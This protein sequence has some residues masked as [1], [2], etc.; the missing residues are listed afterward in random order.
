MATE[1]PI[2]N[3]ILDLAD[4][5]TWEHCLQ[6]GDESIP[7]WMRHCKAHDIRRIYLLGCGTSCY[8]GEVG[9]RIIERLVGLPAEAFYAFDLAHYGEPE[10]LGPEALVIGISTTG[11]SQE[12][13]NALI[14]AESCGASTLALTAAA[15]GDVAQAA[16]GAVLT[17]GEDDR[18]AVKS[19]SYVQTLVSLFL[20]ALAM[21]KARGLPAEAEDAYWRAQIRLAAEGARR[22]LDT[23]RGEIDA[24][25]ATYARAPIVFV[26]GTGPNIG[27]IHE[28]A[29]KIIEMAKMPS[30]GTE[31]HDFVHGRYR[32]VDQ[33]NPFFIVAPKGPSSAHVLDL[34]TIHD[35]LK[36]PTVVI[37]DVVSEAIA[38]LATHAIRLPVA[39]DEL[40]SPMLT[41]L[42]LHLFAHQLAIARGWD[43]LSRRYDELL[44][45]RVKYGNLQAGIVG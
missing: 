13:V 27:T 30:E 22:F 5:A 26:L 14:Y 36:A 2:L 9:K 45:A 10:M 34:L 11:G 20:V 18:T 44:P 23:Q 32:E 43:P 21:R 3:N 17:G 33:V 35:Y 24:L 6:S 8:A 29:L 40:A 41:I 25:V 19:K 4:W 42:P 39:L 7:R 16:M 28:G 37:T 38:S 15:K 1:Y 12:V 31:L